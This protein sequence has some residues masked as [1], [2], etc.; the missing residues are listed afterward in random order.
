MENWTRPASC[1]EGS[2][3]PRL[4]EPREGALPQPRVGQQHMGVAPRG[5]HLAPSSFPKGRAG[6]LAMSP[7]GGRAEAA[8]LNH[9]EEAT[10]SGSLCRRKNSRTREEASWVRGEARGPRSP[11]CQLEG[12]V[13][14]TLRE[15]ESSRALRQ[16]VPPRM[17]WRPANTSTGPFP[18]GPTHARWHPDRD[19]QAHQA[20]RKR[21]KGSDKSRQAG[22]TPPG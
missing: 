21:G 22:W 8:P 5:W 12:K 2:E 1:Q 16:E 6:N 20:C 4:A 18:S 10:T 15:Q 7:S 9:Q 14:C 13:G 17:A 11:R 3:G 19:A